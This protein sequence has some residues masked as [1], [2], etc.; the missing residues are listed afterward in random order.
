MQ[1]L[2]SSCPRG[3]LPSSSVEAA[4]GE[5]VGRTL[6]GMSHWQS[7]HRV[8]YIVIAF[9]VYQVEIRKIRYK[10]TRMPI[11]LA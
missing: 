2:S 11:D 4:H 5:S 8:L 7:Q 10:F 6:A 1:Q 9:C 3:T